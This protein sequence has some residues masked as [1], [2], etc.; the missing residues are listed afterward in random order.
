ML[1]QTSYSDVSLVPGWAF[2]F[3][4][5][6]SI[7]A[8]QVGGGGNFCQHNVEKKN[9]FHLRSNLAPKNK[10]QI[11]SRKKFTQFKS[12]GKVTKRAK[13]NLPIWFSLLFVAKFLFPTDVMFSRSLQLPYVKKTE[14]C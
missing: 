7:L 2:S 4:L 14:K 12:V 9:N 13:W 1:S 5:A 3:W 8:F 11:L 10:G 6:P